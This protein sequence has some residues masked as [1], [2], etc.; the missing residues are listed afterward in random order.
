MPQSPPF[1]LASSSAYRAKLLAKFDLEF[2]QESPNIDEQIN[3][4]EH[5][6][7]ASIRL[8][9]EKARV[10]QNNYPDSIIIASDQVAVS[11]RG[12]ILQKPQSME[13][14]VEQ[15]MHSSA[16]SVKFYTSV[17]VLAPNQLEASNKFS[18]QTAVDTTTVLFKHLNKEQ[19]IHYL[20]REN[21]LDC[22]GSFKSEGL[23][24]A[25][26]E[27]LETNDPNALV[28]LPLIL[29]NTMLSNIGVNVL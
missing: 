14:A 7:N 19:I 4:N 15:L 21:V 20:K 12:L 6:K 23:G 18:T 1:V 24:I 22:A 5:P 16:S 13:R 2:T 27:S 29:L 25:L 9:L 28:G 17:C 10:T 3:D 26:F 11:A 8:A